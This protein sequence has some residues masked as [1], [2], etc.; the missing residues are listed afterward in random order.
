MW[1]FF[2]ALPFKN[3]NDV[4]YFSCPESYELWQTLAVSSSEF[5][6]FDQVSVIERRCSERMKEKICP[7]K[8][9][10]LYLHNDVIQR[11]PYVFPDKDRA[12]YLLTYCCFQLIFKHTEGFQLVPFLRCHGNSSSMVC[13][14]GGITLLLSAQNLFSEELL[15]LERDYRDQMP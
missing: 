2:L 15:S 12:L 4:G 14:Q 6:S 13:A 9:V 5:S 10:V 11:M 1:Q 8:V 7:A 3:K